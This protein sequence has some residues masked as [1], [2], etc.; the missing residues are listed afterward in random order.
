M[1]K[2]VI[3]TIAWVL[4]VIGALNWGLVGV[5]DFDLV[6]TILGTGTVLAKTVYI[7]VGIS[8][9]ILIGFKLMMKGMKKK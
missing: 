1:T 9:L 7:L 3:E 4:V 8:A 2:K 5:L 6:A